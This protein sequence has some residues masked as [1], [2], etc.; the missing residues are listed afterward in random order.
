MNGDR[1]RRYAASLFPGIEGIRLLPLG[2]DA[3]L[4]NLSTNG[5]LIECPNRSAPGSTVTIE[6]S[7][8][9]SPGLVDGRVIRCEVKGIG[10]DGSMRYH[11]G[12]AFTAPIILPSDAT[13]EPDPRAAA[14]AAHAAAPAAPVAAPSEPAAAPAVT[15]APAAQGQPA[16]PAPPVLRNRW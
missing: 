16:A 13:A 14:P 6:F 4:V 7:G 8:S 2:T 12:L 1:P 3:M 9:F 10:S 5:A 11:I 15:P